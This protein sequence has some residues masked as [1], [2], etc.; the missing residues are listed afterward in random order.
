MSSVMF[1]SKSP[2]VKPLGDQIEKSRI[3][4]KD[5]MKIF[6]LVNLIRVR[7]IV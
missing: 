3:P 7:M 6:H 1:R 5:G 4:G 2:V